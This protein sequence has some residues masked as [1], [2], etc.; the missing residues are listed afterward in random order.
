MQCVECHKERRIIARG[1]CGACYSRLIQKEKSAICKGCGEFKPIKTKGFCNKCYAN[2]LRHGVPLWERKKKGDKL[3][4]YCRKRPVHAKGFCSACYSRYLKNGKPDI[5][6]V[7]V[8]KECSFCGKIDFLAAKGLCKACYKRAREHGGD[9]AYIEKD[10]PPKI[11]ECE[12]CGEVR[13]IVG[14]G[15]CGACYQ[16]KWNRGTTEYA[17]VRVRH[18]CTVEGCDNPV[19]AYGFCH[20]HNP[21]KPIV[22]RRKAMNTHLKRK[23][24]ITID[25]YE[26]MHDEQGG[27][28]A[29]C[30]EY[31]SVKQNGHANSLSVDHCHD[32]GKVR[33]LLCNKCNVALG[34]FKDSIEMLINAVNYLDKHQT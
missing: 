12:S 34:S 24:G 3:C 19:E 22:N 33:G 25:D 14:K 28:C 7:R 31:E 23:F 32:T 10:L 18:F 2:I 21:R 27:V 5:V 13:E 20:K 15:L 17:P 26:R 8:E 30:G 4:S 1:L 6:K 16:R 29:I 11:R 9:P